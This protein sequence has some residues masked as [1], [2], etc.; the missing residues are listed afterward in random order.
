MENVIETISL[1]KRYPT[2]VSKDRGSA[3]HGLGGAAPAP[4]AGS[5]DY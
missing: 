1:V 3:L 4:S 2:N 5:S